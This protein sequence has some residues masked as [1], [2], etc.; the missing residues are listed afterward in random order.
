MFSTFSM[1]WP[2]WSLTWASSLIV[3]KSEN[4]SLGAFVEGKPPGQLQAESI[5]VNIADGSDGYKYRISIP[6]GI[7]AIGPWKGRSCSCFQDHKYRAMHQAVSDEKFD[8]AA[9]KPTQSSSTLSLMNVA[10]GKNPELHAPKT[11]FLPLLFNFSSV[12]KTQTFPW[13]T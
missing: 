8:F 1:K 10:L 4:S 11:H 6:S 5:P 7:P 13:P 2:S 9:G 3:H 12:I